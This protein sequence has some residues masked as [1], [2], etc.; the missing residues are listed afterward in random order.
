MTVHDQR[1][2]EIGVDRDAPAAAALDG[3]P[4]Q[5]DDEADAPVGDAG[6]GVAQVKQA[7]AAEPGPLADAL[8][9]LGQVVER[10][11]LAAAGQEKL[12]IGA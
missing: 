8:P 9:G 7:H 6:D 3:A 11:S 10:L 4:R 1:P 5:L 12:P 2:P